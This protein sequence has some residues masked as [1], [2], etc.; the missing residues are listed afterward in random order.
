MK[1]SRNGIALLLVMIIVQT[2]MPQAVLEAQA[3]EETT[4]AYT[5]ACKD[6]FTGWSDWSGA[7]ADNSLKYMCVTDEIAHSGDRCILIRHVGEQGNNQN[8][9]LAQSEL[10]LEAGTYTI[11]FWAVGA[12]TDS[13]IQGVTLADPWRKYSMQ[14]LQAVETDGIWSK[15][16]LEVTMEGTETAMTFVTDGDTEGWYID[17]ISLIK[18]GTTENLVR[19]EGFEE[20]AQAAEETA[21]AYTDAC[22]DYFT[23]WSD[24]SGAQADNNLKFMCVTDDKAHSGDHSILIRHVGEQGN[25]QNICL[26]QSGLTLEAGTYTISFWAVG[27]KTDSDI[28]GVT[29]ADPWRKYSMQ[30]LQA[31]ETD[32]IWSKYELE[33]TMEGTETAMTFVTDGDTEGWY[34]DD[35]SLVKKNTTNNRIKN[36]GFEEMSQSAVETAPPAVE[37]QYTSAYEEYF[38][39]WTRWD[40]LEPD[41]VL[42]FSCVTNDIAH[43]GSNSV[44]LRHADPENNY[45]AITIAQDGLSLTG[46]YTLSFWAIGTVTS[47]DSQ[48][49]TLNGD[50]WVKYSMDNRVPVETDEGWSRYEFEV[51]VPDGAVDIAIAFAVDGNTNGWYIDDV[52]L[53]KSGTTENIL[54][55]G[56]FEEASS[57]APKGDIVKEVVLKKDGQRVQSLD[58]QGNYSVSLVLNNYA[59]DADLSVDQIVAIYDE[60]GVLYDTVKSTALTVKKADCNGAFTTINTSFTLPEGIFTVEYF[61]FDGRDTLNIIGDPNPHR[62]FE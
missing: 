7:Q 41:G 10:T 37:T 20:T 60:D 43:S 39:G 3:A 40:A 54:K 23:G 38:N 26:A 36:E 59:I 12:K 25:N 11:S 8:I 9:C 47:G 35:I 61:V 6:Y 51:T 27:T 21:P 2:L 58:G 17:D 24:W 28:Q 45:K 49:F 19:N 48:C 34:I 14:G 33:V 56:G 31:V 16:E 50:E 5:D 32:G 4:P 42:R 46:A 30:G 13:G 62:V 1:K 15:Y 53:V 52:S 18:Q 55:N 57:D 44:L 22:K 29:L